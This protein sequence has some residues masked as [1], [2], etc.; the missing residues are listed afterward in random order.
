VSDTFQGIFAPA[1]TPQPVI[2]RLA[3]E[4]AA[5]L[6]RPDIK[7]K[8]VKAGLPVVARRTGRV[9]RPHRPRGADVQGDHRQ[10]RTQDAVGWV[11]R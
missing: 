6:A 10:G 7:E 8:F 4:L 3:K 5:I 1:G 11:E 2:D 9:P